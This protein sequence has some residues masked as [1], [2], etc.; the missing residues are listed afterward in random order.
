MRD[1]EDLKCYY[2]ICI[3]LIIF[4]VIVISSRYLFSFFA[5]LAEFWY[6]SIPLISTIFITLF[7]LLKN[8][9][10]NQ[11]IKTFSSKQLESEF[12]MQTGIKIFEKGKQNSIYKKWLKSKISRRDANIKLKFYNNVKGLLLCVML[13][14][15]LSSAYILWSSVLLELI[16]QGRFFHFQP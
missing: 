16:E 5:V 11:F 10:D 8:K 9:R 3:A 1:T 12:E 14:I 4:L 15:I 13:I 2:F 6:V 7:F